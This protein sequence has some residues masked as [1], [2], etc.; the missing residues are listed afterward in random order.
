MSTL[1]TFDGGGMTLTFEVFGGGVVSNVIIYPGKAWASR[2]TTNI[3]G[4]A[5]LFVAESKRLP[6][7]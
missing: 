1:T 6:V 2:N 4:L 3:D 7:V 5:R